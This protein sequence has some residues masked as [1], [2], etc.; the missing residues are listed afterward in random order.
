MIAIMILAGCGK[1]TTG[2]GGASAAAELIPAD[3]AMVFSIEHPESLYQR[4]H[5]GELLPL[6]SGGDSKWNAFMDLDSLR[7]MGLDPLLPVTIAV[8]G[9]D[10]ATFAVFLEG[11][12]R[13]LGKNL[14]DVL[15][16]ESQTVK[17]LATQ[18]NTEILGDEEGKYSYFT[19]E[20]F[21]VVSGSSDPDTVRALT[22]AQKILNVSPDQSLGRSADYRDAIAKLSAGRDLSFYGRIDMESQIVRAKKELAS[23]EDVDPG[24]AALVEKV[25]RMAEDV[26]GSAGAV[27][28]IP[29]GLTAEGYAGIKSGSELLS[30]LEPASGSGSF[31]R[32][33]PGKPRFLYDFNFNA[34]ALW[35][36]VRA[37]VIDEIEDISEGFDKAEK[38]LRQELGI[39]LEQDL[40]RQIKGDMMLLID[41][42]AFI[43]SDAVL[44]FQIDRPDVFQQTLDKVVEY[45]KTRTGGQ[46][47][48]FEKDEVGGVSF[49]IIA[50]PPFAEVCC[51]IVENYLVISSTRARFGQIVDGDSGFADAL[52]YQAL[53]DAMGHNPTSLFYLD[54]ELISQVLNAF[55]GFIQQD[56]AGVPQM[57]ESVLQELKL[58]HFLATGFAEDDGIRT[59][60]RIE[61]D[62]SDFWA[63]L[64]D[65]TKK[66]AQ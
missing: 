17:S 24:L 10:P 19:S 43:G 50:M 29:N 37:N 52:E 44:Y 36:W 5:L 54:L 27:S 39:E 34:Q 47:P 28:F 6:M 46:Q 49:Y 30:F 31:H 4:L 22:V 16:R 42:V 18:E 51:G 21:L 40:I 20:R 66:F 23:Q 1:K 62:R 3:A 26:R 58:K 65:L 63:G 32:R 11:D 12:G 25:V 60:I 61:S 35:T 7:T 64:A 53:T 57:A 13:D 33:I 15:E 55:G 56:Q 2:I 48:T 45:A 9:E 38:E 59:T 14:R 8:F 41:Q